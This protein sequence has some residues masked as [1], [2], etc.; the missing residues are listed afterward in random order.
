LALPGVAKRS[1]LRYLV[2]G[3]LFY[4]DGIDFIPQ[5]E[6]P[7]TAFGIFPDSG[8]EVPIAT[9]QEAVDFCAAFN[10]T[11]VFPPGHY[12]GNASA[13]AHADYTYIDV[14]SN[15]HVKAYDADLQDFI[16]R[17]RGVSNVSFRGGR[18]YNKVANTSW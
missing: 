7:V 14:P 18:Y 6:V 9:L 15:L 3:A 8:G 12:F 1:D 5:S 4:W 13:T 10:A 11:L 2:Q 17:A 16:W